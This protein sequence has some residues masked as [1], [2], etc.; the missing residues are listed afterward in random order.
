MTIHQRVKVVAKILKKRFQGEL[1][2]T[3]A[4]YISY[5]IVEALD[6]PKTKVTEEK[7]NE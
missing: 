2:D 7:E 6:K 4:I 5:K 3:E 1:T